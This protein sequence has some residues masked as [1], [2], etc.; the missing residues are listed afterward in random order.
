M[1]WLNVVGLVLDI[2][3]AIILTR[4]LIVSNHQAVELGRGYAAI[5]RAGYQ[6]SGDP[7]PENLALPPSRT[8]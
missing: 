3:G 5:S 8:G 4:G 6:A 2:V 7:T 1:K